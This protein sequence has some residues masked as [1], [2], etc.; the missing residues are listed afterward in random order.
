MGLAIMTVK[1]M[2]L[3][4]PDIFIESIGSRWVGVRYQK[5]GLSRRLTASGR[6]TMSH[7]AKYL[8]ATALPR[9]LVSEL[10]APDVEIGRGEAVLFH[11]N[12]A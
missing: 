7:S 9:L 8:L 6:H 12:V 5:H 1:P 11:R 4:L 2:I 3:Q 10:Y